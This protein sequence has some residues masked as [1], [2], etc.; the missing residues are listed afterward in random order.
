VVRARCGTSW[1]CRMEQRIKPRVVVR[2]RGMASRS[3]QGAYLVVVDNIAEEGLGL[4][5]EQAFRVNEQLALTVE[6]PARIGEGS[7]PTILQAEVK[8]VFAVFESKSSSFRVGVRI[9]KMDEHHHVVLRER[10]MH[11]R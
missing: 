9:T 8:V 10:V 2:W 5:S 4:H 7:R 3:S 11:P 1:V 6:V